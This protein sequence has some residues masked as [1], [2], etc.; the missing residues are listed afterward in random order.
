M[1]DKTRKLSESEGLLADVVAR[2][3][4]LHHATRTT[5]RYFGTALDRD[6]RP[7]NQESPMQRFALRL[8]SAVSCFNSNSYS[9]L[10]QRAWHTN[11]I[12]TRMLTGFIDVMV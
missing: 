5:L 7:A 8:V 6:F 2:P 12:R 11:T 4:G 9:F 3:G 10:L 1:S